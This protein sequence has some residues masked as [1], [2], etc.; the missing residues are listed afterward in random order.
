MNDK[1]D[2]ILDDAEMGID[3]EFK[4]TVA[5]QERMQAVTSAYQLQ[6]KI[7]NQ[8]ASMR[9]NQLLGNL[10]AAKHFQ[11]SV[12]GMRMQLRHCISTV[13][14]ID[15]EFPEA[16]DKMRSEYFAKGDQE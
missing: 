6:S 8:S 5:L 1:E 11:Q 15:K 3:R 4:L 14:T 16:K 2:P 7:Q 13:K 12:E 9:S 10:Q